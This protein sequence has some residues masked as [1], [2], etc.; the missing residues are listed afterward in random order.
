MPGSGVVDAFP[1][2][3]LGIEKKCILTYMH[4]Y[5]HACRGWYQQA[6][7]SYFYTEKQR[8]ILDLH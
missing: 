4:A 2:P 1:G 7:C 6:Q 3:I 5:I 8:G